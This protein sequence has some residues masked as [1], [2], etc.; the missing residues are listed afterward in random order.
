MWWWWF[1]SCIHNYVSIFWFIAINVKKSKNTQNELQWTTK[2]VSWWE[3]FWH[4]WPTPKAKHFEPIEHNI[5]A[6]WFLKKNP[7][8]F[9][10]KFQDFEIFVRFGFSSNSPNE[11]VRWK[12]GTCTSHISIFDPI[13]KKFNPKFKLCWLVNYDTHTNAYKLFN[14]RTKKIVFNRDVTFDK[15]CIGPRTHKTS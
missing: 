10:L 8:P 15:T 9:P 6:K 3:Y 1:F 7:W 4:M 11:H 2:H 13:G 14:L 12:Q 5:F